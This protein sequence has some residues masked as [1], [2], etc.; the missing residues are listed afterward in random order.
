[1]NI[2]LNLSTENI[3]RLIEAYQPWAT[4]SSSP[5]IRFLSKPQGCVITVYHS[6]KVM[7]QGEKAERHASHYGYQQTVSPIS[8]QAN[9]IGTDEVGNGS[10]FGGLAVVATYVAAS[11]L[12]LIKKLG[13]TDSKKLTD[14]KIRQIAP[15]LQQK[16]QHKALLL[17]PSKY[18]EVIDSGYN[19]VS[20]KVALHNQAIFLL[21]KTLATAADQ[22]II[23]AFTTERNYATYL[24][25]EGNQTK[26]QVTLLQKAES[27]VH[28]VA[29]SSVIA[30]YLFLNELDDLSEKIGMKLPSGA[31]HQSDQVAANIIKQ[32]GEQTLNQVA[33]LH[34]ANTEK[35]RRLAQ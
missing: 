29:V 20:V 27:Q 9:I 33:K 30:R 32:Y 31:G 25:K 23:D 11:D 34:F 4:T 14:I 2:V 18:N 15:T 21:E 16:I 12:P 10:Y 13:V 3:V 8:Q 6:G 26:G 24:K 5:H 22:I 7:F 1:M 19:A 28:A 17:T 35:A